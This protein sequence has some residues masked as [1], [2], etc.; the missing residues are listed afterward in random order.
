MRKGNFQMDNIYECKMCGSCCR[1]IHLEA[2]MTP[3]FLKAQSASGNE[4]ARF[5]LKNW[6]QIDVKQVFRLR[7]DLDFS[8]LFR[9]M[10]A[11]TWWLC[12]LLDPGTNKCRSHDAR[13]DVCKGFPFYGKLPHYFTPYTYA[14]GYY[15][16]CY[17]QQEF[18]GLKADIIIVSDECEEEIDDERIEIRRTG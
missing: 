8:E 12:T 18:A 7:S 13:P 16:D 11:G 6:Q 17:P 5:I 14:C 1:A 3:E 4:D 2:N 15:R 10:D 9:A